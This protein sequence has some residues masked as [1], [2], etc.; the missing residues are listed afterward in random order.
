MSF[1]S[2]AQHRLFRGLHDD[3]DFITAMLVSDQPRGRIDYVSDIDNSVPAG[4]GANEVQQSICDGFAAERLVSN[5]S[6]IFAQTI[7][8]ARSVECT[9]RHAG[10]QSF[11][12]GRNGG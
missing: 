1:V 9:F 2:R 8:L 5:Q 10:S 11:R 7:D 3:V 4:A 12:A 6:Q